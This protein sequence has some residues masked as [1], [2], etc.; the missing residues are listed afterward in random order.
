[1]ETPSITPLI[2]VSRFSYDV[3]EDNIIAADI[4]FRRILPWDVYD[5]SEIQYKGKTYKGIKHQ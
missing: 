2:E 5:L 3:D 4:K 1:M